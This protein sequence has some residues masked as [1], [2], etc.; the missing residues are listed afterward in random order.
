MFANKSL[1]QKCISILYVPPKSPMHQPPH[2]PR[3]RRFCFFLFSFPPQASDCAPALWFARSLRC[4]ACL[5]PSGFLRCAEEK[6][7]ILTRHRVLLGN[8]SPH[9]T[10]A[11]K[12]PSKKAIQDEHATTSKM[13][14]TTNGISC[15]K[16]QGSKPKARII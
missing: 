6:F 11:R 7:R 5:P 8:G 4:N 14:K 13:A 3:S 2:H 16:E 1:P 9:F 12:K 15:H 10:L